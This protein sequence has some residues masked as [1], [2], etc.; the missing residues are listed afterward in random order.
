[1]KS[2]EKN[3]QLLA[4]VHGFNHL[5]QPHSQGNTV[6]PHLKPTQEE[7]FSLTPQ[8]HVFIDIAGISNYLMEVMSANTKEG[9]HKSYQSHDS[10]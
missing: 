8:T 5:M 7:L 9:L 6:V 3:Q 4:E 10:Y 2:L 1:M